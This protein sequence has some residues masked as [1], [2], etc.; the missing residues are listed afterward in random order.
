MD[1]YDHCF[2]GGSATALIDGV[3]ECIEGATVE[4]RRAGAVIA[5]VTTD[6]FGD[7]KFDHLPVDS[8]SYDVSV[9]HAVYGSAQRVA[10]VARASVYLGSIV[11]AAARGWQTL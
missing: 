8:G 4:L 11:L 7:F 6:A 10:M 9:Y 5:H 1:R 2:I 3:D